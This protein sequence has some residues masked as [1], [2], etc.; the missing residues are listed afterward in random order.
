[1]HGIIRNVC[2]YQFHQ[3]SGNEVLVIY[4][5]DGLEYQG[6]VGQKHI[7]PQSLCSL[8]HLVRGIQGNVYLFYFLVA[9]A[10]QKAGIIP[11]TGAVLRRQFPAYVHNLTAFHLVPP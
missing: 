7:R 9:S 4:L 10:R 2:L 3:P 1:V 5:L 11:V 8:H 6:M